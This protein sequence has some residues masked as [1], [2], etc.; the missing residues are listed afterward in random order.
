[1]FSEGS[2]RFSLSFSQIVS[3]SVVSNSLRPHA[4]QPTKLICLWNSPSKN[5]GV[6][7]H[8]LLQG[9][10]PIQASN[11]GLLHCRQ[12]LFT[13]RHGWSREAMGSAQRNFPSTTGKFPMLPA[14]KEE[15]FAPE[16]QRLPHLCPLQGSTPVTGNVK[17]SL[18]TCVII[19]I[20]THTHTYTLYKLHKHNLSLLLHVSLGL[21]LLLSHFSRV[22]LCATP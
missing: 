9:I 19:S 15:G 11:L 12:I 5:T 20:Y 22:R 8:S 6:G 13:E 10:F 1:M 16:S 21:L 7:S 14:P 4:L 17:A 3:C 18:L 2:R